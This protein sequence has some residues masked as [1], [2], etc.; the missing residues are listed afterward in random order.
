MRNMIFKSK[1]KIFKA[2]GAA[3]WW[4]V[5]VALALTIIN[6]LSAKIKGKAPKIFGYSIMHVISGSMEPE[7]QT[8]AYILVKECD[9]TEICPQEDV[10]CFYSED[11]SIYGFPNTHRVV[12]KLLL[13][14]GSIQFLTKGD[15]NLTQDAFP[16]SSEN[17]IGVYVKELSLLGDLAEIV[18]GSGVVILFILLTAA[19]FS[20]FVY[21]FVK[22]KTNTTE[23]ED[24]A[25]SPP[26]DE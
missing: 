15:A 19:A 13:E 2:V 20:M 5:L 22:T 16:V 21:V 26:K 17:V 8:G 3:I 18:E 9:P 11:P 23:N 10:I 24:D 25:E 12:E 4:T 6:I 1:A 14:D 7:I